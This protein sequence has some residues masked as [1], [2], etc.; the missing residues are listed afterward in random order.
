[1]DI[2][3]RTIKLDCLLYRTIKSTEDSFILQNDL[4]LLSQWVTVWQMR[5]IVSKCVVIRCSRSLMP[6]QSNYQLDDH[7]LNIKEVHQYLGILLHRSLSWSGH[8]TKIC[9]KVSCV[10][11]FLRCN[12]NKCSSAVKASSY[13]IL[14]CPIM[15]YASSVWDPYQMND[16][17][18]LEKIQCRAFLWVIKDYDRYSSVSAM[19][20]SL[21]WPSL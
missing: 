19:L 15:E 21:N 7:L 2:N 11:N 14:V 17:Q 5:F 9:A 10:F 1:M 3:F 4:G 13:L 18:A 20:H 12:L 6:L 16:I 8:I